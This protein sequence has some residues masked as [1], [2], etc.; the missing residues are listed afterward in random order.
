MMQ[1][2]GADASPF[3]ARVRIACHVKGI[4]VDMVEPPGGTKS[5][6]F[7][8]INPIGKVP[9][10]IDDDMTIVESET[11]LD[12]IDDCFSEPSLR[13]SEPAA[14]AQMRSVIRITD[15]YVMAPVIR[16]FGQLDP[17][18]RNDTIVADEVARWRDGM[19][20]LAPFVADAP[21][22]VGV[23]LTLADC[24]LPPSLMLSRVISEMLG[25]DDP[26]K[27]CPALVGYAQKVRSHAAVDEALTRA[28]AG[29]AR[30]RG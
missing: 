7:L 22:A 14:R 28:E 6:E 4:R 24:V 11:I 20:W 2:Y 27:A 8:A 18:S 26:I 15:T 23:S 3:V 30:M 19:S 12:Y 17:R 1:L 29:I 5:P 13:P 21:H 25:I 16:L 9:V 10:L